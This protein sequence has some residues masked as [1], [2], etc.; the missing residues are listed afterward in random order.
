MTIT[1]DGS[2]EGERIVTVLGRKSPR[3]RLSFGWG[4]YTTHTKRKLLPKPSGAGLTGRGGA[5]QG[6]P[7]LHPK[8]NEVVSDGRGGS[9]ERV[10][11][12]ARLRPEANDTK[13]LP[14]KASRAPVRLRRS[15]LF[16]R[17]PCPA[18]DWAAAQTHF[19]GASCTCSLPRGVAKALS[20]RCASFP[21]ETHCRW[22]FV[23]YRM[24]WK[25]IK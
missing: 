7:K 11:F 24:K 15:A 22:A 20:F 8:P 2:D 23:W 6:A 18:L 9:T 19:V 17:V 10:S 3:V 14:T 16:S 13:S 5:A 1:N 4:V 25:L 12:R 21:N